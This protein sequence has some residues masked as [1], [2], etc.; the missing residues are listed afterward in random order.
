[1]TETTTL[2]A[3]IFPSSLIVYFHYWLTVQPVYNNIV[4]TEKKILVLTD[5][6]CRQCE[7]VK[8]I[9]YQYIFFFNFK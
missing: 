4:G 7:N 5:Y 3:K 9:Y 6:H 2:L 8:I 1:M